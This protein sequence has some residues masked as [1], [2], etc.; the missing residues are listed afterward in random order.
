MNAS[1]RFILFNSHIYIY[2]RF[3]IILGFSLGT[4][5]LFR[6]HTYTR[7]S[8]LNGRLFLYPFPSFVAIYT[9]TYKFW[10]WMKVRESEQFYFFPAQT[11]SST[12]IVIF[13]VFFYCCCCCCGCF[14]S[15]F[16]AELSKIFMR[17]PHIFEQ[18]TICH[19][20]AHTNKYIAK[21]YTHRS[22]H[23]LRCAKAVNW[24]RESERERETS[25]DHIQKRTHVMLATTKRKNA[26]EESYSRKTSET[27]I[28]EWKASSFSFLFVVVVAIIHF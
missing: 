1:L 20:H 12:F 4:P 13:V 15:Y 22:F 5:S 25:I 18:S 6:P 9:Y 21:S 26:T 2:T 28:T 7:V 11:K 17:K 10:D 24:K 23:A 3:D 16:F 27:V 19:L 14:S 8:T